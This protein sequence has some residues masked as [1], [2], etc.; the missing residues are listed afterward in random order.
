MLAKVKVSSAINAPIAQVWE[1]LS[2]FSGLPNWFPSV[3]DGYIEHN[4]PNDKIGCIRV[5]NREDGLTIREQLLGLDNQEF[6][7]TYLLLEPNKPMKD[8]IGVLQLLPI[9]DGNR[10]YIEWGASFSCLPEEE[11]ELRQS[12]EQLF[13]SGFDALNKIFSDRA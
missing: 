5:Y 7:C 3:I 2:D 1:T 11:L 8:Y 9:T 12:L 13:Q 6:K 4:Q 10:T